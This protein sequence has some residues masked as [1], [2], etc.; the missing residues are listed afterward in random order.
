MAASYIKSVTRQDE[1]FKQLKRHHLI[2]SI[3]RFK[4]S[5]NHNRP[6]S[7]ALAQKFLSYNILEPCNGI[8]E[9]FEKSFR[10]KHEFKKCNNV[11]DCLKIIINTVEKKNG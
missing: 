1:L 11:V 4:L 10:L 6:V 9:W 8:E 7:K 2:F 3:N 5:D